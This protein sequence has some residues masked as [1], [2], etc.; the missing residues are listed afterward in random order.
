MTTTTPPGWYPEPGHT[1][2][3]PAMERWWDGTAWT[4]YTRT[5]PAPNA[6]QPGAFG[7]P[8]PSGEVLAS[9]G[10][11]GG[12]R[13]S[14]TVALA[15]IAALV[16]IGGVI[17][18]ILVLGKDGKN[19]DASP[20][21]GASAPQDQGKG[22]PQAPGQTPTAPGGGQNG[23]L[24]GD[25]GQGDGGQGD[26]GQGGGGD[27]TKAVDGYDGVSLP[28]LNGWKGASGQSGVGASV[29]TDEYPCPGDATQSC[30]RGGAF[31]EPAA[32]LKLKSTTA[33]AA[34][35]EDIAPNVA[36]SYSSQTYGALTSHR[37]VAS[38]AVTVAGQQ[39][40]LVRWM[41]TTKSGTDG[42]VESLAFPSPGD[43]KKLVVVRF[44]FDI[45]H[46]A[47]DVSAMDTIT[48]GIKADSSGGSSGT[49]V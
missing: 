10:G 38:K 11:T 16:V 19:D 5:A 35:K 42:Y 6:A 37:V 43:S 34:A 33:E 26:G 13:K 40:Y 48:S 41:I 45:G 49:G 17:A 28:V 18:G 15:I 12:G 27:S 32:A 7:Y 29:T 47:P 20:T 39:G 21:P 4:E 30:V 14:G 8:Y 25:G 44:G 36:N 31:A 46:G 23:G 1:G 3:G 22:N 2:N 24:G 9:P